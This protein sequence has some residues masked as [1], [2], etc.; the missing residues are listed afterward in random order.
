MDLWLDWFLFIMSVLKN[1][2]ESPLQKVVEQGYSKH[3]ARSIDISIA[4]SCRFSCSKSNT[5]LFA[6]KFINKLAKPVQYWLYRNIL[7]YDFSYLSILVHMC[8]PHW[9][10]HTGPHSNRGNRCHSHLPNGPAGK[11]KQKKRGKFKIIGFKKWREIQNYCAK[12]GGKFKI[13]DVQIQNYWIKKWREIQNYCLEKW[14][15]IQKYCLKKWSSLV[16]FNRL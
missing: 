9:V 4:Y 11:L 6:S 8:S 15:E 1:L 5:L 3:F 12:I 7:L 2:F 16:P 14:R 13:I 10:D